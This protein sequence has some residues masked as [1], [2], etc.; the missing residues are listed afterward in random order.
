M[1]LFKALARVAHENPTTRIHIVPMLRQA[2]LAKQAIKVK[3]FQRMLALPGEFG[4]LTAYG[5]GSKSVNKMKQGE[6][7]GDLQ[8]FGYRF[9][10]LKGQW[11]NVRENSMFV[12]NMRAA[13]LFELGRKYD[14]ISVI[15]KNK[16]GVVGMYYLKTN[17][18]EVAIK[19]DASI[20]AEIAPGSDL[21]SKSRGNSFSFDF[22][23]GQRLP[24][25][26]RSAV[27]KNQVMAWVADGSL[28]PSPA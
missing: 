7:I 21:W 24:W 4:I 19:P 5:P 3:E 17:E 10:H 1:P 9:D 18:V 6:L 28:V 12:P 22:L 15:H 11:E 2:F 14:Q 23:W 13:D 16:S 26:G 27:D 8:K 20:A 25:D